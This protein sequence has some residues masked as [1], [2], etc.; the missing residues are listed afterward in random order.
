MTKQEAAPARNQQ[1]TSKEPARNQQGT[2]KEPARNQQG[3]SKETVWHSNSLILLDG[4][5]EFSFFE[6]VQYLTL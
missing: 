5:C 1:G 6:F 4:S 2:S 3:T